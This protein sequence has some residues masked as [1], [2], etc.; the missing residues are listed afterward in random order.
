MVDYKS[1]NATDIRW[2]A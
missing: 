2:H 1:A